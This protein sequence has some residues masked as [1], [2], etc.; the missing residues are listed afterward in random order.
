VK[1]EADL[2][3]KAGTLVQLSLDGAVPP[4]PFDGL[5]CAA[6]TGWSGEQNAPGWRSVVASVAGMVG[7]AGA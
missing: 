3:R 5:P 1:A 2:A 4:A 6:M 7:A